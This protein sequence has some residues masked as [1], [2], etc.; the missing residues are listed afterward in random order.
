MAISLMFCGGAGTVTGSCFLLTVGDNRILIDCGMF[1]GSKTEK[2]L[3]YE[4]F[5]FDPRSLESVLLT[6]AHI[7]HSGLLPKLTRAGFGGPV[8]AT[9]ATVDLC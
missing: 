5:P 8:F 3:N 6:H 2:Q 4:P 7:D 9:P 1:Q